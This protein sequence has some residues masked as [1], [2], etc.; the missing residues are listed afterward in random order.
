V[1]L[2]LRDTTNS[3]R[4]RDSSVMMSSTMPSAK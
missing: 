2:E 3:A 4:L 1:K